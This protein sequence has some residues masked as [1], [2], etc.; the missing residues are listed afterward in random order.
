MK[1]KIMSQIPK[2]LIDITVKLTSDFQPFGERSRELEYGP[3]CS[4]N[5]KYFVKL[6]GD[7][8]NDFGVCVNKQ[9]PRKGLLTFE[10]MG[11]N[12]YEEKDNYMD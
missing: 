12:S 11:C 7:L 2:N 6:Q 5:C 3:D 8:G 9:S 10:H 1:G 4:C